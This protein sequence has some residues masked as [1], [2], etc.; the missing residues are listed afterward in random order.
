MVEV[1]L[2]IGNTLKLHTKAQLLQ[3]DLYRFL[4]KEM[5][6]ITPKERLQYLSAILN[7]HL[8]AYTFDTDD[9]YNVDGYI[10]KRFY[11]KGESYA[12]DE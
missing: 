4:K 5:P 7:N 9:E 2:S 12:E 6:D 1:D 10:V 11:P 3:E 8:E